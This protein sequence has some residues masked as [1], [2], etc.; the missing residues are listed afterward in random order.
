MDT[1]TAKLTLLELMPLTDEQRAG[2]DAVPPEELG[3][4][5]AGFELA[6]HPEVIPAWKKVLAF[7]AENS[8]VLDWLG[9]IGKLA[10]GAIDEAEKLVG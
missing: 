2:L 3:D 10:A 5:V 9:P 4:V 7:C 8:G 1:N 6:T